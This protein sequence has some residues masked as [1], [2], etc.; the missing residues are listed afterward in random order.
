MA[1]G[2][3]PQGAYRYVVRVSAGGRSETHTTAVRAAAFELKPSVLSP[4]RGGKLKVTIV[5]AEPL[6]GKP[7]LTV[8]QP[9]VRV[10]A[11]KL[12]KIGASTYRATW[13]LRA[14][15]RSG[16]L[17]LS[18]SGTDRLGGRNATSLSLHIR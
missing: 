9:G 17:T 7:R 12:T 8:R 11:V 15:G 4:R 13:T 18:V 16:K 1:G 5:T 6:T 2:F 10:Y 3:A 14:G